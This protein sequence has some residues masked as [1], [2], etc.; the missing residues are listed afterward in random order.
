MHVFCLLHVLCD[1]KTIRSGTSLVCET[2]PRGLCGTEVSPRMWTAI[3]SEQRLLFR[4][5]ILQCESCAANG[6]HTYNESQS[7]VLL[8]EMRNVKVKIFFSSSFSRSVAQLCPVRGGI[9]PPLPVAPLPAP[10]VLD[11]RRGA[12]HRGRPGQCAVFSPPCGTQ[13]VT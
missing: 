3:F 8:K 10:H 4:H 12:G 2:F 11:R 9:S 6:F 7:F 1:L 13:W 5:R